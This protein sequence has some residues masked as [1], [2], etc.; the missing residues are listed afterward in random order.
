MSSQ[1]L[2]TTISC[3]E[4]A[5]SVEFNCSEMRSLNAHKHTLIIHCIMNGHWSLNW[6][7]EYQADGL[8]MAFLFQLH[9]ESY[10]DGA[11]RIHQNSYL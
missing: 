6:S 1:C 2:I 4:V 3:I 7:G 9:C 10:D 5:T 11:K 8:K